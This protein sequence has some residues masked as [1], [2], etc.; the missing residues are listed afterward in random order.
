MKKYLFFIALGL[1]LTLN[2]LAQELHP[3]GTPSYRSAWLK[4]YQKNP[5]AYSTR[6]SELLYVPVSIHM[7]G[8]DD[9]KGFISESK[10][11]KAIQKVN[12]DFESS[13]I[14]FFIKGGFNRVQNSDWISH[15]DYK[16]GADM[17]FSNNIENS[18][19]CYFVVDPAGNCG[20][21]L[22]YAGIAL[23]LNCVNPN[24]DTWAHE[25]GHNLSLPH[26][27]LGWEGGIFHNGGDHDYNDPAPEFVTYDY[28]VFQDVQYSADDTLIID[29]AYV[30]KVDGSNC[31]FAADGF[32]DTD[33]DYLVG[34]ESCDPSTGRSRRVQTDPNGE[35]FTSDA[36]LIMAYF[37]DECGQRF[38]AE[39]SNAMR[40][41]LIDQKPAYLVNNEAPPAIEGEGPELT[42]PVDD[43]VVPV[44]QVRLEWEAV[45]NAQYYLVEIS[46]G[47]S[48]SGANFD[49]ITTELFYDISTLREGRTY[50]WKITP[51]TTHQFNALPSEIRSFEVGEVVS[52]TNREEPKP[53]S[54][55]NT[56]VQHGQDIIINGKNLSS[57]ASLALYHINGGISKSY[58]GNTGEIR[59][60]TG[61]LITGVYILRIEQGIWSWNEK[62]TVF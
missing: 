56:L 12:H 62:I 6:S 58:S 37:G 29:T 10:L 16:V 36:S 39:Q 22:P 45:E 46:R 42:S 25:I 20:Y 47:S 26:P 17:M 7:V 55:R 11:F 21:N 41:N 61:D 48:V 34:G 18:I 51:F 1:G 59:I 49:T 53:F 13:D 30:E 15:D 44:N 31:H 8:T 9:G 40:A 3:C 57:E 4:S 19:N 27:F 2:C 52:N 23:A 28:T 33:P 14:Q 32:C 24:D 50:Y 43:A 35:K 5:S 38:T 54:L 60:N